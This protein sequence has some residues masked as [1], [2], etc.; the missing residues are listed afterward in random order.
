[1]PVTALMLVLSA[2]SGALAQRIGPRIPLTAGPLVLAAGMLV[3]TGIDRGD[4]YVSA[5]LPAVLLFGLGLTLV[6][7]PVTSTVLAAAD[8][9]HAGVASGT[10]NAVFRVGGLLAV[11]VLP[12]V[13]GLGG[14]R[15]YDPVTMAEGFRVAMA[16][17]ANLAAAGGVLAW[18]TIR[19]DVLVR[20]APQVD[21]HYS[22]D[23][24]GP[25][26]RTR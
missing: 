1:M 16:V 2:R 3:M 15:F 9:R 19:D 11:A 21:V 6:V 5:V 8:P 20:K 24:A 14:D 4:E 26:L 18:F 7:A 22:C 25:P 13:A 23:V 12:T 10:N 17:C